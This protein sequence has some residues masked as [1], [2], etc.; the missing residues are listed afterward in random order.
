MGVLD[1][2]EAAQATPPFT[3]RDAGA[4]GAVLYEAARVAATTSTTSESES[5]ASLESPT[6]TERRS[7]KKRKRDESV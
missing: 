6:A 3:D 1:T 4:L 5:N 2:R 7:I